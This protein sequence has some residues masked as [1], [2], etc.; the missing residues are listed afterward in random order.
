MKMEKQ[1][2]GPGPT[3]KIHRTTELNNE[4]HRN[5]GPEIGSGRMT[6]AGVGGK[7]GGGAEGGEREREKRRWR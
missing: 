3:I 4:G 7:D 5:S 6:G 2:M 1:I